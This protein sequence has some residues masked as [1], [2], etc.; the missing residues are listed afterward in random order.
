[1][2]F[3]EKLVTL[4]TVTSVFLYFPCLSR[5][6]SS[7]SSTSP[8]FLPPI[9]SLSL[10]YLSE[11]NRGLS[12]SLERF[13]SIVFLFRSGIYPPS[14]TVFNSSPIIIISPT[15][16]HFLSVLSL[17]L[18]SYPLLI[19]SVFFISLS[20]STFLISVNTNLSFPYLSSLSLHPVTHHL[21]YIIHTVVSLHLFPSSF[22]SYPN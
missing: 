7:P 13:R 22:I 2:F 6:L 11:K 16:S 21:H 12:V 4:V 15:P 9:L 3:C 14:V 18:L 8:A 5:I 20:L 10:I 1:M 17:N 19:L